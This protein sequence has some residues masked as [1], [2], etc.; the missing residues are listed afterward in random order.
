MRVSRYAVPPDVWNHHE[1]QQMTCRCKNDDLPE[2][3]E[4]QMRTSYYY[5]ERRHIRFFALILDFDENCFII[6]ASFVKNKVLW[7]KKNILRK[8]SYFFTKYR[9][10]AQNRIC[11]RDVS[12]FVRLFYIFS[13]NKIFRIFGRHILDFWPIISR[14]S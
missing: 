13:K 1:Q 2:T 5:A 3:T 7:L 10:S 9:I 4:K 14:F 11:L 8:Q 6:D 12:G